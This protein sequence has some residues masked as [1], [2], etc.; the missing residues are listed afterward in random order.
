MDGS[1]ALLKKFVINCLIL[2]TMMLLTLILPALTASEF[3][4]LY[5]PRDDTGNWN[6]QP[7]DLGT[8]G[9]SLGVKDGTLFGTEWACRLKEPRSTEDGTQ[10]IGR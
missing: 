4:G 5:Y 9:G 6:C 7:E 3:E 2:P 8:Y 1:Q 10:F